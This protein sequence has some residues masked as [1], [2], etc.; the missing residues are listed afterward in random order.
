MKTKKQKK[1]TKKE[2]GLS[3]K[4]FSWGLA[5][6]FFLLSLLSIF[7]LHYKWG[8]RGLIVVSQY[9]AG[10][11]MFLI[12]VV[13]YLAYKSENGHNWGIKIGLFWFWFSIVSIASFSALEVVITVSLP[14]L[15]VIP[16]LAP[17]LGVLLG[18]FLGK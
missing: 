2:E 4:Q 18:R 14:V 12:V 8:V 5:S 17:A 10:V 6:L 9:I 1:E 13:Q 7:S 15:P 16:L 11:A 3:P